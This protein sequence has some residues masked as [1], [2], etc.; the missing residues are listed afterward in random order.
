M[1][2][3]EDCPVWTSRMWMET[4]LC[5]NRFN[6]AKSHYRVMSPSRDLE[7]STD[8]KP[9]SD[10]SLLTSYAIRQF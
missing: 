7:I 9:I 3:L 5:E 10:G 6:W 1:N 4:V 2:H 8:S